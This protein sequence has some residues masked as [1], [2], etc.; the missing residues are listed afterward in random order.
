MVNFNFYNPVRIIFG[1]GE[2]TQIGKFTEGF[3]K[4]VL[5]VSY[6]EHDYM[7][8]LLADIVKSFNEQGIEVFTNYNITANPLLS[9]VKTSIKICREQAI[10]FVV[11]VGGG[12]VMDAAKTIAVGSVY[13]GEVWDMFMSRH[14]NTKI[15]VE[16][17]DTLPTIMVPTLPAT[18]S[19]MN[20]IA[21]ITNDETTEK[22]YLYNSIIYPKISIIDPVITCLLPPY[23]TACGAVDAISHIME[24]YFNCVQDTPLQDRL[25]EG[26]VVTIIDLAKKILNNP[27]DLSLRSSMQW[28][29][30]LAWNGWLQAGI[31]PG[32]PMHQIGHVLSARHGITHGAT[33]GIIMPAFFRYVVNQRA[34]RFILFGEKMLG[35]D[36]SGFSEIDGANKAI[37]TFEDFIKSVG[38]ETRLSQVKIFEDEFEVIANDVARISCNKE[39][40][41]ASDPPVNRKGIIEILKLAK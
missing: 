33:L 36:L 9:Q 12:S 25:Q 10:N 20:N 35:L 27:S 31:N 17:T 2:S 40:F 4:K 18:S 30:C 22:S 19:E 6:A 15:A 32:S 13:D 28:A 37:D 1:A 21:V 7:L 38:V 23:Q 14:D 8:D 11:G 39:G 26:T 41:L 5:V 34:G 16:P 24:A 3:G 29:S